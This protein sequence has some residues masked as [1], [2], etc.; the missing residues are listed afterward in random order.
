MADAVGLSLDWFSA[1]PHS[2]SVSP[3]WTCTGQVKDLDFLF[4]P[5]ELLDWWPLLQRPTIMDDLA[6]YL[7]PL[8][9][10][11]FTM[12]SRE[13]VA[14]LLPYRHC[15]GQH[16]PG[17]PPSVPYICTCPLEELRRTN[18]LSERASRLTSTRETPLIVESSSALVM[19]SSCLLRDSRCWG[20]DEIYYGRWSTVRGQPMP[21]VSLVL[22]G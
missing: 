6:W 20:M 21:R 2:F 5:Q 10:F 12:L 11:L 15:S 14:W 18:T 4:S 17:Q 13:Q 7:L 22:R 3:T 8:L 9:L 19:S 1:S 16:T